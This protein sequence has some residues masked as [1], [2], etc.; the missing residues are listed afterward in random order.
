MLEYILSYLIVSQILMFVFLIINEDDI[1]NG[2]LSFESR[3]GDKPS[4]K[5]YIFYVISHII[6]APL[7]APMILILILLN[8]GKLV[9]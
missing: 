6:K 1:R 5:W 4:T 9:E 8:G 7:L 2:Y 3:R